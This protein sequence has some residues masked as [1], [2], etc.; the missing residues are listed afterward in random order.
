MEITI[1]IDNCRGCRHRDHSGAFTPGGAKEICGHG[2][3]PDMVEK[4]KKLPNCD[5][6]IRRKIN[7]VDEKRRKEGY[8]LFMKT[9]SYWK[10]RV[11]PNKGNTIP[12][13]CPLKNGFPY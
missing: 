3:A 5:C 8:I 6:N 2:Y 4:F 10:N 13:W 12:E 1:H 9:G 11:L 7:S